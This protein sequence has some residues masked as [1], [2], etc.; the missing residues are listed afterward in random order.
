[1]QSEYWRAFQRRATRRRVLRGTA[2][3]AAGIAGTVTLGACGDDDD[4]DEPSNGG[5]ASPAAT[6]TGGGAAEGARPGGRFQYGSNVEFDTFDPHL[7]IAASTAFFPKVYNLVAH[8]S[9]VDP[10][11][12]LFDLSESVEQIDDLT[13]TFKIRPG[14]K[15]APNDL[16]APERDLDANDA[17][18]SFQRIQAEPRANAGAFVKQRVASFEA[19]DPTTFTVRTNEPYAWF[20]NGIGS[21]VAT[22]VPR[23]LIEGDLGQLRT[24][25]AGG[26]AY[27]L[28][29]FTEGEGATLERNPNYYRKPLPYIDG[30]DIKV[31]PDRA[32]RRV[33][34]L[35][36]QTY[37]Y[38][39]ENVAEAEDLQN[40]GDFVLV[41]EPYFT[42]YSFTMN[43]ERDP[44]QD[45]RIRRAAHRAI[46]RQQFADVLQP[47]NG[48]PNGLV[49][50][51]TG[52]YALS[53]DELAELQPHDP[54]EARRL[55]EE[56]GYPDGIT[57]RLMYP[58]G[59]E[60]PNYLPIL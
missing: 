8:Q 51:P 48:R 27:R 55:L 42:F 53:E 45:A 29:N 23:E 32:A 52:P 1:M 59:L 26:G 6:S 14:V 9:A 35:D 47:G 58:S 10:S 39:A 19:P 56:A 2:I 11:F 44:W 12:M 40:Q 41:Q 7:S 4:D 49:H 31:I 15:I 60:I 38:Q 13:Y 16:G 30:Y 25:G 50:W 36:R 17:L 22:V 54:D 24:R 37:F 20:F 46:N 5:E 18:V 57:I 33:A 28:T 34:F 21:F 43:A 3:G